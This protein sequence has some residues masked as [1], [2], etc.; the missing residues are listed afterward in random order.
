M[1]L[2]ESPSLWEPVPFFVWKAG[3]AIYHL[4]GLQGSSEILYEK[5]PAHSFSATQSDQ[6]SG[7][8]FYHVSIQLL[9]WRW[10]SESWLT[11]CLCGK[12]NSEAKS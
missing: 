3:D 4:K 7:L 1:T 8:C 9:C 11:I 6:K 2:S 12:I 5:H 10:N